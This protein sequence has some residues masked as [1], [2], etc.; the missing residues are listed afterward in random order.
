MPV[1]LTGV[2]WVFI[3]VTVNAEIRKFRSQFNQA[4]ISSA[5]QAVPNSPG[6]HR[7]LVPVAEH[8]AKRHLCFN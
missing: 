4:W 7:N 1:R 3:E 6:N 5:R 8:L 2:H